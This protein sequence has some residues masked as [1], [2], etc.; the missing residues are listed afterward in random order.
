MGCTMWP[1]GSSQEVAWSVHANHGGGYA[2]RLCPKKKLQKEE[3]LTEECFQH[4][5]LQF[6]SDQSWI[7]YGANKSNRT[8]FTT[9]RISEGTHPKGSQWTRLPVP[10]CGDA[11]GGEGCAEKWGEAVPGCGP[12][13]GDKNKS[14][15]F[16]CTLPPMFDPPLPGLYGY[17]W[18]ACFDGHGDGK[19]VC[20]KEQQ[21][22]Q[23][24]HF[25]FNIIDRVVVP[26]HLPTGEYML[27]FRWDC[28]QTPQIWTQCAD[29]TIT[30]GEILV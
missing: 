23:E 2:Y 1:Q 14:R 30:K 26:K 17:G 16:V 3:N 11:S 22:Y 15:G 13:P 8:A 6:E 4:H 18:S 29:V 25:K 10:A 20:T 28:E 5:H 9:Y 24:D 19:S 27:S 7:Q 21:Q 12:N